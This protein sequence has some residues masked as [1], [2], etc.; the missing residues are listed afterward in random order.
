[1]IIKVTSPVSNSADYYADG[2]MIASALAQESPN[3]NRITVY[4]DDRPKYRMVERSKLLWGLR[5]IIP[6]I[7]IIVSLLVN[8]TYDIYM[9]ERIVGSSLE[10]WVKPVET[11]QIG[12][13]IYRTYTHKHETFSLHKNGSQVALISKTY[14]PLFTTTS[15][16]R[17]YSVLY[18]ASEPLWLIY[19]FCVYADYRFF[20]GGGNAGNEKILVFKDPYEKYTHWKP[21]HLNC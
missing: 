17:S 12:S 19:M 13:D 14:A 5:Q 1:M 3:L 15:R 16:P 4:E 11:F 9:G 8:P 7:S 2:K 21:N 10:K 18:E 20:L 6:P